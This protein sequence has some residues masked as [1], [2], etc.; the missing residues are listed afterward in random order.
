MLISALLSISLLRHGYRV[1][2]HEFLMHNNCLRGALGQSFN[3]VFN[4]PILVR[5]IYLES[6]IRGTTH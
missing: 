4:A 5:G 6:A 1:Q 3:E 2:S